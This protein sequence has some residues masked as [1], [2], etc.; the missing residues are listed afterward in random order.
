M[1]TLLDDGV[2]LLTFFFFVTVVW[3]L[4]CKINFVGGCFAYRQ[5]IARVIVV[6]ETAPHSLVVGV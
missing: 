6:C 4:H 2:S 3:I 5:P 1:F